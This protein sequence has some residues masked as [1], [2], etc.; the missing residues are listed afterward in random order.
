M[1]AIDKICKLMDA[2]GYDD[3]I[4]SMQ[5]MV[6]MQGVKRWSSLKMLSMKN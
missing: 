5:D 4:K 1:S 3:A 6:D 2:V